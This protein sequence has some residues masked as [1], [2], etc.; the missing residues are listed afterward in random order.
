MK[1]APF[2]L[3]RAHSVAE[4]VD[5]LDRLGAD[6][7]EAR[8]I[9]GGQSLV[10]M[11]NFRLARPDHLVDLGPVAELT[12]IERTDHDGVDQL[13]IGAMVTQAEALASPLV[14]EHAPMLAAALAHIGH[15]HIRN[16]GTV[17]GSIAHADPAAELPAALV[18]LDAELE[19]AAGGG[20]RRWVAAGDFFQ[21][22]FS[23]ALGAGE[24]LTAVRLPSWA[25]SG[26]GS[27]RWGFEELARRQGDFAMALAA[28]VV[29]HDGDVVSS[30]RVVVGGVAPIPLRCRA[31]EAA[32]VGRSPSAAD[33]TDVAAATAAA[34]RAE[35]DPSSDVHADAE[36][37][38]ELVE[39]LVARA[40]TADH[41][42]P[43][44]PEAARPAAQ[45]AARPPTSTAGSTSVPPTE[46][47][48]VVNGSPHSLTA[49]DDRRLLAD[50]LRDDVGLTGT[51]LGCEHGVCGACTVLVDDVPVRSCLTFAAQ[52][53]GRSITTVEGL[54][55]PDDLHPIQAAFRAHHGL[56]CGFCTPGM[57][58]A[59]LDL[60]AGNP[61]PTEAEIREGLSGNLCRCTGYSKIVDA[62]LA[63]ARE[64]PPSPG[65]G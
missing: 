42:H 30:A 59:T 40:L 24:L 1:P 18:A 11:M 35:V 65:G 60:L 2:Q 45:L 7:S 64:R 32:L 29:V 51:H 6:G 33:W 34:A 16:R 56:Q 36:Y 58:L 17:G 49:I 48:V 20:H 63:A 41:A 26:T 14:A 55:P 44:P 23:T 38:R 50:W 53:V 46:T 31:A 57:V 19:I 22:W 5:L 9:A 52:A 62:V 10:P 28:T 21:G 61:Q 27:A 25:P 8:V 39:V 47:A 43:P 37:R 12:A 4:A 13:V 54:G 3:H 15:G